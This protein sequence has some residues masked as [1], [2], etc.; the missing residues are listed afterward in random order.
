MNRRIAISVSA[1]LFSLGVWA[2]APLSERISEVK[3]EGARRIDP[4][5][6]RNL[7]DIKPGGAVDDAILNRNVRV[8][9]NSKFFSDIAMKTEDGVLVITVSESPI[10]NQIA[11]EGNNEVKEEDIKDRLLT[12]PRSVYNEA[13]IRSDVET[14]KQAYKS[15]GFF[16]ASV[17]AKTIA[18][19]DN[20]YDIVFEISEGD[21]A[22]IRD[23]SFTGNEAF[24]DWVLGDVISSRTYGWWKLFE[25]M[26]A[27]HEERIVY[28]SDLL[29]N[30][31]AGNGYL[32]YETNSYGAK[33]DNREQN[34]YVA[35]DFSEGQRYKIS[36]VDIKTDI[37]ELDVSK[38]KGD[39][40][41]E[42][43]MFYSEP[44]ARRSVNQMVK[45]MG[46]L[47]YPFANIAIDKKPNKETGEAAVVF[48]VTDSVKAFI[49]NIE[50]KNNTRTYESVIRRHLNFDEQS[51]YNSSLVTS[52]EQKL[53]A[54]GYFSTVKITPSKVLSTADKV[55][56]SVQVE[57][58]STGEMT[59][60]AGWS[61]FD[62]GFLE[63]GVKENNFMGR[64]QTLGFSSVFS[65]RQNS[66]SMSFAEPYLF[67]RDLMGGV[68][69]F[70]NQG[71]Y[72]SIYGYD[73]DSVGVSPKFGWSYNDN[74]YHRFR[75][76]ARHDEAVNVDPNIGGSLAQGTGTK[77]TYRVGHTITYRNQIVDYVNDTKRG[78]VIS[79]GT[80][81]AGFGG[82]KNFVKND[83][84]AKQY[85]SFFDGTW[86][87]GV[88]GE[89]GK[90]DA[91]GGT[92]LASSDRYRLGGD[93][94]R[95]FSYNGI[96]ARPES[97]YYQSYSYGG[98]WHLNGTFQL[99]FPIGFPKKA[100]VAGYVFYDWGYM[101]A[102]DL[103]SFNGVLYDNTLRTSV[104]YGISW[105]SPLGEINLSWG[106]PINYQPYDR[107]QRFLFSIGSRF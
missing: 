106:T 76:T 30:F 6:I 54:L 37:A 84:T 93:N 66:F 94:L 96:G 69:V 39:V 28:D 34:F 27:Y 104:G 42:S 90:I 4:D 81:Y 35:F 80:D 95:G 16:K 23:I 58:K 12:R 14:L 99:N 29:R 61:T 105:G 9:W 57:E 74:L 88:L 55:D 59:F 17:D 13:S 41:V 78:H 82:D 36:S 60:G 47:G 72:R 100:R 56:I 67:G 25:S 33:M 20:R 85:F 86:M 70:Y 45:T 75:L 18:R 103:A 89:A 49:N 24:S 101:G 11:F 64:G 65:Q 62:K 83:A 7:I 31:Y 98:N 10:V 15:L 5:M 91:L 22:Y 44:L 26:D 38:L 63:L 19:S 79:Y 40:L 21:K 77:D 46:E 97:P 3:V 52:S 1:L 73:V 32:D 50:V 71:K 102:P 68:D 92:L 87:L 48:N 8:L 43:G 2:Q 53:M 107:K 51:A